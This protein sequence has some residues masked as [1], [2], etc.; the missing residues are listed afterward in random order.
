MAYNVK[1]VPSQCLDVIFYS[2]LVTRV[3]F[4]A[5]WQILAE[6]S[7]FKW[8]FDEIA[9]FG[10]DADVANLNFESVNAEAERFKTTYREQVKLERDRRIAIVVCSDLQALNAKMFLAYIS[11]NPPPHLVFKL[12]N[13]VASTVAWIEAGRPAGHCAR[14]I[15]RG[16][17]ARTLV[18][19]EGDRRRF[20]KSL[21]ARAG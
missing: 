14:Q 16:L 21:Q 1:I 3:D 2:S 18:E 4:D 10:P 7:E 5:V 9:M 20:V 6:S 17:I 15:D 13:K 12:F 11:T 19:L 8:D